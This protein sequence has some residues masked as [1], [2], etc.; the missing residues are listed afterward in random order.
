MKKTL[1]LLIAG[2]TISAFMIGCSKPEEGDTANP[3]TT[4]GT[5]TPKTNSGD[6]TG[7]SDVDK[8][9]NAKPDAGTPGTKLPGGETTGK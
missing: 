7:T 1:S 4:G 2:L 6:A 5:T 8:N 3:A 9:P